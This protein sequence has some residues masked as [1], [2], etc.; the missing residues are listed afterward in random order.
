MGRLTFVGKMSYEEWR[1]L[2]K[3]DQVVEFCGYQIPEKSLRY[4]I[5]YKNNRCVSCGLTGTTM[6]LEGEEGQRPHFNLYCGN[7]LMTKD[8]KHPKALGG[9]DNLGN[10]QT[11]CAPCNKRKGHS[12][13]FKGLSRKPKF[14][15]QKPCKTKHGVSWYQ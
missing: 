4:K 11:M 15:G 7:V 6:V 9:Q 10:L 14:A 2:Y 8:H 12:L 3:G 5:F 1:E 13:N